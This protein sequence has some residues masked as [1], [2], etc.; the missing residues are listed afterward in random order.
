MISQGTAVEK[1]YGSRTS[2]RDARSA[3]STATA[4]I[5]QCIYVPTPE[6]ALIPCPY[7]CLPT[8]PD[9]PPQF[10]PRRQS[11]RSDTYHVRAS[12]RGQHRTTWRQTALTSATLPAT[13]KPLSPSPPDPPELAGATAVLGGSGLSSFVVFASSAFFLLYSLS[14][15]ILCLTCSRRLSASSGVSPSCDGGEIWSGAPSGAGLWSLGVAASSS[16]VVSPPGPGSGSGSSLH[17]ASTAPGGTS[18]TSRRTVS[19]G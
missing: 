8:C 7:I 11:V 5:H 16:G 4:T 10:R 15:L 12:D 6:H 3:T 18:K 13:S 14:T 2:Q 17:T 9:H 1:T 19:S